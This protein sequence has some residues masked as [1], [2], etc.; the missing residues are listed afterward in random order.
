MG[1]TGRWALAAATTYLAWRVVAG[2]RRLRLAGR[3]VVITGGSR[4][5]GLV[6][7][8]EFTARGARLAIC[9][10]DEVEL[11]RAARELEERGARVLAVA[12][13]VADAGQVEHFVARVEDELGPID[14]LVNNASIIQVGPLEAMT[15][16][17]FREAMAVNYWGTVHTTLAALPHMMQRGRGA[18]VNIASIG[19]RVAVPHLVPYDA[20]KFAV[21]GFSRGLRAELASY[22]IRVTTIIPGLMRTGSP[23]N[24]YFKGRHAAEFTWFALGDA[25]P[26]TAMSAERAARRIVLATERGEGEVVLTW[27]AKVLGL[28]HDL[29]P[30]F[31]TDVLGLVDR[32]LPGPGADGTTVRGMEVST[33]LAPSPITG[34]MNRAARRN[35]EFGG[36]LRPAP[37]HAERV[38]L[39]G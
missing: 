30:G 29:F 19:G 25:T 8:R 1:R 15:L 39:S 9:A 5:L 6:L 38:G 10:R 23:V 26:L 13:D 27:Q 21:V 7:A 37:D 24:A 17:D 14:V 12:C 2:R 18:I 36:R 34:L 32:L 16:D 22:G 33:R 35:N 28:A 20:A 3:V 4:G 31:T 11:E